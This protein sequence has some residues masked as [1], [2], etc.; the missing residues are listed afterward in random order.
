MSALPGQVW[1]PG[2]AYLASGKST[3]QSSTDPTPSVSGA[4]GALHPEPVCVAPLGQ[5]EQWHFDPARLSNKWVS[6]GFNRYGFNRRATGRRD[7]GAPGAKKCPS[8]GNGGR[9][10]N[11][12]TPGRR[13][14]G[15]VVF[16]RF[17]GLR[18]FR[19]FGLGGRFRDGGGS[20]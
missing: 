8:A 16:G 11:D 10:G 3:S 19:G 15:G 1:K 14:F 2:P 12:K 5:I 7:V 4:K 20:E 18:R 9:T 17:F 6:Y 13:L